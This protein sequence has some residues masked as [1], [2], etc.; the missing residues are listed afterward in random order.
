MYTVVSGGS[1]YQREF[2]FPPLYQPALLLYFGES[3]STDPKASNDSYCLTRKS[4]H[5][6]CAEIGNIP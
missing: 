6:T 2:S 4:L 3:A 1:P 5:M